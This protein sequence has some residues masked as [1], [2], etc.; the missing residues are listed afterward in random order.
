MTTLT[1]SQARTTL[2]Q[3]VDQVSLSHEPVQIDGNDV[4]IGKR[5]DRWGVYKKE[6]DLKIYLG[7]G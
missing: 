1:V 5:L 2:Y 6:N 4:V 7:K 3:L